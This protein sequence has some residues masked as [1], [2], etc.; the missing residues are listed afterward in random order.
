MAVLYDS[1][2]ML[3]PYSHISWLNLF[4]LSLELRNNIIIIVFV[5]M[6]HVLDHWGGAYCIWRTGL[7]WTGLVK[8]GL[9]KRGL[10]KRN[11]IFLFIETVISHLKNFSS[12]LI[13]KLSWFLTET[14]TIMLRARPGMSSHPVNTLLQTML[15]HFKSIKINFV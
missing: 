1:I 4:L 15:L 9:V 8:R 7:E 6:D 3:K 14:Y 10:V 12:D 11:K 13:I 5:R 2:F